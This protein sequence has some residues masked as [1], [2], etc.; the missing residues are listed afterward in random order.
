MKINK[1]LLSIILLLVLCTSVVI[2]SDYTTIYNPFGSHLQYVRGT[3]WSADNVSFNQVM[4]GGGYGDTGSTFYGDGRVSMDGDLI[5]GGSILNVSSVNA[6]GDILP[7]SNDAYDLGSTLLRWAQ[8]WFTNLYA[9]N[10]ESNLDG[11]GFNVSMDILGV[12]NGTTALPSIGFISDPN[13]GIFR[14]SADE[15]SFGAG[16]TE[17]LRIDFNEL[18]VQPMMT[19]ATGPIELE[20]NSG[21]VTLINLPVTASASSSQGYSF[22]IDSD[23]IFKVVCDPDG[24]G[25]VENCVTIFNKNI[26]MTSDYNI[27]FASGRF[28]G[29]NGSCVGWYNLTDFTCFT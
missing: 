26:N 8:G 25:G 27:T 16:G 19:L 28:I 6:T 29:D 13:T 14:L 2:A 21:E 9:D 23:S 10:L 15:L 1:L 22:A 24:S 4:I 20:E 3:N 17:G 11:T 7:A 5:I 12:G 18:E